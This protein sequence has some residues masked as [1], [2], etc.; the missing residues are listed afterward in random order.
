MDEGVFFIMFLIQES[1]LCLWA[2]DKNS[3]F[4][5]L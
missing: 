4:D 5:I 2:F 3:I 1:W